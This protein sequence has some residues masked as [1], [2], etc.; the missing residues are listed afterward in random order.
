MSAH[1]LTLAFSTGV[2]FDVMIGPSGWERGGK[3][4]ENRTLTRG[5]RAPPIVSVVAT[6]SKSSVVI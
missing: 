1:K 6:L 3:F 2:D 4:L 5:R